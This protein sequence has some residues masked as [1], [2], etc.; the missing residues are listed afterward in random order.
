MLR[1]IQK[2]PTTHSPRYFARP[3]YPIVFGCTPK[4]GSTTVQR[5]ARREG[6]R[7][8]TELEALCFNDKRVVLVVREPFARLRS[9][10]IYFVAENARAPHGMCPQNRF[11]NMRFSEFVQ[12][13]LDKPNY[14]WTPQTFQHEHW[15]EF[16]LWPLPKLNELW[17]AE[18]GT[19]LW[20]K[21]TGDWTVEGEEF[22]PQLREH[23]AEDIEMYEQATHT[24]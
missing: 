1:P 7:Q 15:R 3:D 5:T 2:T 4:C 14:H 23:Y 10:Y 18:L 13:T 17:P 21:R 19:P 12:F 8:V 16:E 11:R 24:L 9:A 20:E 22:T 6:F